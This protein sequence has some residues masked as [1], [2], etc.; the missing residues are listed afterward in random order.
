MAASS[1][2]I[3]NAP[4]EAAPA[5]RFWFFAR[6]K[7]VAREEVVASQNVVED[8]FEG[9]EAELIV[10][11][12]RTFVLLLALGAPRILGLTGSYEMEEFWLA[13]VAG[14]YNIVTGLSCLRPG[15]YGMRR[16]FMVVMD[17]MLV[18]LWIR[19]SGQ[20]E[21]FPFYFLVVVVAG[22]WF[23][24]LGG[25]LAA[26]FCN[27]FFLFLWSRAASDPELA[28]I[29]VF[30]TSM[31][32]GTLLLFLV[33][34]LV[35]YI[36]EIQ[37]K[38]RERRLESQLLVANYQREIDLSSQLQPLLFESQNRDTKTPNAQNLDIGVATKAARELGGG[39]YV[40]AIALDQNRTLICIADVSGKSVR[41]QA[42]LPLLKYALR[43]LAPLH[44]DP[45]DLVKNLNETLAPDLQPELYIAFCCAVIDDKAGVLRWC[46]A[47]HIAPLAVQNSLQ[48]DNGEGDISIQPL[49]TCGPPLGLFPELEYSGREIKWH[50]GDQLLLY[51]DGLSDAL[52]F[53]NT[54]D[55]EAQVRSL[56]LRLAS[57]TETPI[58]EV[59]ENFV[60]LAGAALEAGD[61]FPERL[62][63]GVANRLNA[64]RAPK[65]NS[66]AMLQ[67]GSTPGHR[68]DITVVVVRGK[69]AS[70]K[71]QVVKSV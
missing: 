20:W 67:A 61:E 35:G 51:T 7:P 24:V 41:A 55:G 44:P 52:S 62:R 54:E 56:A 9:R 2:S 36:A 48:S 45:A 60:S 46:N 58:N 42:R 40:D 25:A 17:M 63:S 71:P 22:M 4:A 16:V 59:A 19:L 26:T 32:L 33:G 70:G 3:S 8:Q 29:P 10:T 49:E 21:L 43:A 57:E 64:L 53:N 34:C 11:A 13:G 50:E 65:E 6:P 15:Q 68:D 27:F 66:D 23:K 14:I 5:R 18:T 28:R 12:F 38:E 30:T 69:N 31:A 39:D 1:D 37:D 47:G